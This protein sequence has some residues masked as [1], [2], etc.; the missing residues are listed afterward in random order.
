[1]QRVETIS[2]TNTTSQS[3]P[4]P[5][6]LS[7][8]HT[9]LSSINLTMIGPNTFAVQVRELVRINTNIPR[10]AAHVQVCSRQARW[11]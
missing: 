9:C 10:R 3:T 7:L 4:C 6:I 5:P 8:V 11:R 2:N 1:M